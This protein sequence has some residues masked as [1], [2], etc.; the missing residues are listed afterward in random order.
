MHG[1]ERSSVA[2]LTA[3][4]D[5]L[6]H[7]YDKIPSDKTVIVIPNNNPDGYAVNSRINANGVDLNRNF[8]AND[9][10]SAVHIPGSFLEVGGGATPLSEPESS[11]L[12]SFISSQAPKLV[13][14]YHATASAVFANGSG[15]SAE[16]AAVYAEK[17]GFGNYNSAHED[18]VFNYPTTGE[19]ETWLYDKKG[20]ACILV[21]LATMTSNE[22]NRQKPAMWAMLD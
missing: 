20:F 11:A 17:S 7:N 10:A 8:P 22:I 15:I 14:T 1:N 18:E 16:R 6:E 21:E 9:W 5:E 12:A 4:I 13:L 2:T 19:F 3:W